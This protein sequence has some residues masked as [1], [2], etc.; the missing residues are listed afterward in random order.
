MPGFYCTV[1]VR[2]EA[3]AEAGNYCCC[4][5]VHG[6][7]TKAVASGELARVR[8]MALAVLEGIARWIAGLVA[9]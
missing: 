2:W 5:V 9:H 6:R 7:G 8:G 1:P 4:C 3:E